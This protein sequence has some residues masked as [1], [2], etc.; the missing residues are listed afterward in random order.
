MFKN[1][2]E[3]E[4]QGIVHFNFISDSFIESDNNVHVL[5]Q[6]SN[7]VRVGRMWTRISQIQQT[8][9]IHVSFL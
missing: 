1:P 5:I 4:N 7:V 3:P 2:S 8:Y 6:L 9:M